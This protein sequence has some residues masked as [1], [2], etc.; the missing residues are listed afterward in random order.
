M[1]YLR[2]DRVKCV[3]PYQ[4]LL[5]RDFAYTVA[6]DCGDSLILQELPFTLWPRE[7]FENLPNNYD[8]GWLG[9]PGWPD[10]P[11]PFQISGPGRYKC[12]DGV[13]AVIRYRNPDAFPWIGSREG[14]DMDRS[15]HHSGRWNYGEMPSRMDILE[16]LPD[17]P[18]TPFRI[19]SEG[20]YRCRDGVVATI[21]RPSGSKREFMKWEGRRDDCCSDLTWGD[22][23]LYNGVLNHPRDILERLPDE[24]PKAAEPF[25]ITEPGRYK[26]RNGKVVVLEKWCPEL[27]GDYAWMVRNANGKP[28]AVYY[29]DGAYSR[30]VRNYPEDIVERLPDEVPNT[31][32]VTG[33]GLYELRNGQTAKIECRVDGV[34]EFQ[35]YG[36]V[37]GDSRRGK[38][39]NYW[40]DDGHWAVGDRQTS[41][42]VVKRITDEPP[43]PFV[44][45]GDGLYRSKDGFT[46]RVFKSADPGA[47]WPFVGIEEKDGGCRGFKDDGTHYIDNDEWDLC[48]RLPDDVSNPAPGTVVSLPVGVEY[49][50]GD[51][52][53]LRDI[54]TLVKDALDRTLT[55]QPFASVVCDLGKIRD[56][57]RAALKARGESC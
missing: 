42:D 19:V 38:N 29:P 53:A 28:G 57:C 12:R 10:E 23:G 54:L 35:W 25:R 26:C 2:G 45:S 50:A 55:H 40:R 14:E 4:D 51:A 39:C 1:L 43:K 46:F 52:Q 37:L 47:T 5:F 6:E 20:R 44:F 34:S 22:S 31:P 24:A 41:W 13:T 33:P 27:A 11:K 7:R 9:P 36:A 21:L 15:W 17:E 49:T 56:A 48:E 16:R 18:T 8:S 32:L 30:V 3:R